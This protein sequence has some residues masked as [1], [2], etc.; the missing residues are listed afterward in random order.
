MLYKKL[1]IICFKQCP[2]LRS[3]L[4]EL[5]RAVWLSGTIP[6]EWKKACTILIHKKDDTNSPS[7]FRPITLEII[8]LKVFTSCIRNSIFTFLIANNFIESNIQKGFTPHVSGTLEHT[9]QMAYIINQA[10]IKQ[11]SLVITLLD[12][13]NAF[14]NINHNLINSVLGYH[15]IP[16]HIKVLIKSLYTNFKT[17]IITS[18]FNT[19]FIPVG[20]GVLQ[21][22]CLS[23]SLFDLCFNTFIQHIKS[24]QYRQFGFS[25]KLLNPIHWFQF[26]DDASVITS[27]ETENQHLLNRF[28]YGVSGQT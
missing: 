22:D 2:F 28:L 4:T 24:D 10:R 13:K 3:Y 5:F 26:A 14:G 1:S 7:N 23:P 8:P 20:R 11:R 27:L 19:P 18:S 6:D 16:D 17:S 21:G 9:A 15:H 12:L 25:H